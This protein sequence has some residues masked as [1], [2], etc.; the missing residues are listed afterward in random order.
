MKERILEILRKHGC[1]NT[2]EICRA[3]N[4]HPINDPTIC[5]L[6]TKLKPFGKGTMKTLG[7]SVNCNGHLT[8]S[9]KYRYHNVRRKLFRMNL[10]TK[11]M[12]FWDKTRMGGSG[13]RS[14]LFRFWWINDENFEKRILSQTLIPYVEELKK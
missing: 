3:L 11:L 10:K 12:R 2:H 5:G 6:S 1:L 9:C 13:R 14:D 4:G 7:K 8:G